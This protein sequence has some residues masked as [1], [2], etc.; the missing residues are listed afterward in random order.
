MEQFLK[1][2]KNKESLNFEESKTAFEKIM[3]GKV[4]EEQIYDFLTLS[5][6]KGETSDEIAG[7]VYVLRNTAFLIIV[8]FRCAKQIWMR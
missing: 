6:A 2:L 1:K 3:S 5:S 8:S 7:G 4:K